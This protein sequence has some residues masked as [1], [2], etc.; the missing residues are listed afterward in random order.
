MEQF[1][2]N[3]GLVHIGEKIFQNLDYQSLEIC[4]NVCQTW[5]IIIENPEFWIN[6]FVVPKI[7]VHQGNVALENK[8]SDHETSSAAATEWK[9]LIKK[10]F[11]TSLKSNVLKVLIAQKE[12]EKIIRTPIFMA[13]KVQDLYLIHHLLWIFLKK[14]QYPSCKMKEKNKTRKIKHLK[15]VNKALESLFDAKNLMGNHM[16]K[17]SGENEDEIQQEAQLSKILIEHILQNFPSK[18]YMD[19]YTFVYQLESHLGYHGLRL[20]VD[21]RQLVRKSFTSQAKP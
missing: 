17:K 3:P 7:L 2:T 14:I 4:Q 11:E 18:S 8:N 19:R 10:T 1:F 5:K 16:G 9:Y 6:S 20:L 13:L 12:T 21:K 15:A